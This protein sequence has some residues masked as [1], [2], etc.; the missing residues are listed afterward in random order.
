SKTPDGG[1]LPELPKWQ[2]E[3]KIKNGYTEGTLHYDTILKDHISHQYWLKPI[4]NINTY[5]WDKSSWS[6]RNYTPW[7]NWISSVFDE[8]VVPAF[9]VAG[10]RDSYETILNPNLLDYGL[11]KVMESVEAFQKL[12]M[13]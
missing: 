6:K 8:N 1:G 12:S 4:E 3:D 10:V 7:N 2:V 5:E 13:F 9:Y 11:Q